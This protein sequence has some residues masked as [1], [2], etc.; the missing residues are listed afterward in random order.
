MM[1]AVD[2]AIRVR[3][4]FAVGAEVRELGLRD[5]QTELFV[6]LANGG[7]GS[8]LAGGDVPGHARIPAAGPHVLVERALLQKDPR[9][10]VEDPHEARE[11]PVAVQVNA[12]TRL[13]DAGRASLRRE[14]LDELGHSQGSTECPVLT[15]ISRS[16]RR[17]SRSQIASPNTSPARSEVIE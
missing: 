11:V 12:V 6:E 7:A 14:D 4:L 16:L 9:G 1:F 8:R 5:H 10:R 3:A 2:Q 17:V 13:D 15:S